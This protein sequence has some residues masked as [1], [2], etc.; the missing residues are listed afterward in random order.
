MNTEKFMI[1]DGNSILNRAFYG[2]R[3]LSTSD[4]VFT[5]AVLGFLNIMQ[6]Y[7]KEVE[8]KYLCVTFD[9][10]APTFRHKEF[11][12]YK[13]TRKGMPQELVMQVPLIKEVLDAMNITRLEVEGYEAD[14]IIGSLAN[15]AKNAGVDVVIIT[16]DRDSLQ[17]VDTN[18]LVKIPKTKM[19]KTETEDYTVERIKEDFLGLTPKELI[20]VKGLQGDSSDNIP[21]VAGVGEKTALALIS[22]FKSIENLYENIDK[23]SKK[24]VREKLIRDKEMAFLSKKLGTICQTMDVFRNIKDFEVREY[25]KERLLEIFKR[26]EFNSFIERFNLN[27]DSNEQE[28]EPVDRNIIDVIDVFT[29]S[30]IA[31]KIENKGKLYFYYNLE[32]NSKKTDKLE[33]FVFYLDDRNYSIDFSSIDTRSFLSIFKPVFEN[34]KVEKYTHNAKDL[35]RILFVNKINLN[36][37]KFDT[38]I[39]AYLLNPTN[40]Q[41]EVPDIASEFLKLKLPVIPK[42]YE[43]HLDEKAIMMEYAIV[44][45]KLVDVLEKEIKNKNQEKL[46]YSIELPLV[47]VLASLEYWGFKVDKES[48]KDLSCI[49]DKKIEEISKEIYEMVGEEFN[50]NSPKQLGIILAEK[51]GL[52]LKK[53]KTGYSTDAQTLEALSGKSDVVKLILEY[54]KHNKLKSTYTESLMEKADENSKIHSTF[55]QTVTATGRISS[56]EP[57]LQNIPIKTEMGRLVRKAFVPESRDF[58]LLSADYS[59]IELRVLAHVTKDEN[60]IEAFRSNEDIHTKTASKVFGV[61]EEDVTPILRRQ[62]KAINFGI[63][64]GMGEFSLAKDLGITRSEAKQYIDNYFE[65]HPKVLKYLQDVV[66]K[67]EK[68]GYVSTI[69]NRIRYMPELS[70]TNHNIKEFGKRVAMNMPIQGSA[71]D[72]IKIAMVLVY[73]ELK[74]RKLKSRLILQIHD[75]LLIETHVDEVE[76]VSVILK[77]CMENAV[78]LDVPL[79]VEVKKGLNWDE[80]K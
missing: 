49:L 48:L 40:T 19:G 52:K 7:Q 4:G 67:G 8:P 22:E 44:L 12:G 58:V 56:T 59:Q 42:K 35:Y 79:T 54:R 43:E 6:K 28:V 66:I 25:D 20:D 64:Y 41:L 18:V 57:N 46:Y 50:I 11:D 73:N 32:D 55:N 5:N 39:A 9:L 53:T 38:M 74:K 78:S 76:E 61:K 60:M 15:G 2:M 30:D 65:K 10:K 72:I 27:D 71:A 34:D 16:G 26:L 24:G 36:N 68:D 45:N 17:L 14:D 13:A 21:G 33:H 62:A 1:I 75:E 80:A 23:V 31:S 3:L 63:I 70:S 47:E 29:L 51:M 37:L 77:D 69:F